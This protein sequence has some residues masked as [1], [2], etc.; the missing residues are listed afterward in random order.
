MLMHE[1]AAVVGGVEEEQKLKGIDQKKEDDSQD[2]AA[3]S[4]HR[5]QAAA[6]KHVKEEYAGED[7][8]AKPRLFGQP[9]VRLEGIDDL[10][11]GGR[12]LFGG[13]VAGRGRGEDRG[14]TGQHQDQGAGMQG[15]GGFFTDQPGSH[16]GKGDREQH[17]GKMNEQ[18]MQSAPV[19][20]S[21]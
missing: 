7:T 19:G 10:K 2:F 5:G 4:D 14:H 13:H 12:Q 18:R 15:P 9:H 6:Q 16:E 20:Q 8:K 17:D 3:A 21:G 1:L 11:P